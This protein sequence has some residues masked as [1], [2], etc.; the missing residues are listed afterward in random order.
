MTPLLTA[1]AVADILGVSPETVLR[2]TRRGEIPAM[3]LPSG[4]IR[5]RP[6]ALDRWLAAREL[7]NDDDPAATGS[8]SK[9]PP[10]GRRMAPNRSRSLRPQRHPRAPAVAR[11]ASGT[12]RQIERALGP[13]ATAEQR[14]RVADQIR[15]LIEPAE[16][17][18]EPLPPDGRV[19]A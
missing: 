12:L 3:R 10:W 9:T 17:R 19:S 6:S 4:A 7:Y 16:W 8:R 15:E 1:R 18:A 11:V 14:A 13:G 5:Y 2:W